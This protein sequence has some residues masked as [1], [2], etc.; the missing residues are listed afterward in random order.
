MTDLAFEIQECLG[1]GDYISASERLRGAIESEPDNAVKNDLRARLAYVQVRQGDFS[2]AL[3]TAKVLEGHQ[4]VNTLTKTSG[5]FLAYCLCIAYS[6]NL[7]SLY[8]AIRR[9]VRRKYFRGG[10]KFNHAYSILFGYYWQDLRKAIQW[11]IFSTC[12][13]TTERD[14]LV[15]IGFLGY[16]LVILGHTAV[17]LRALKK[18]VRAAREA[19]NV[20]ALSE[21]YVFLG[22]G[23]QFAALPNESL[24]AHKEFERDLP[25]ASAFSKVICSA[26]YMN[27][28][29][30]ERGPLEAHQA[31]EAAFKMAVSMTD[32][33]NHIQLYGVRACLNAVVGAKSEALTYLTRSRAIAEKVL[34]RLDMVIYKRFEA[35]VYYLL[36]NFQKSRR[37]LNEAR[38]MLAEYGG[39]DWYY[40]ELDRVEMLLALSEKP[41]IISRTRFAVVLLL[42]GLRFYDFAKFK[43]ALHLGSRLITSGSSFWTEAQLA[44]YWEYLAKRQNESLRSSMARVNEL[45]SVASHIWEALSAGRLTSL[46]SLVSVLEECLGPNTVIVVEAREQLLSEARRRNLAENWVLLNAESHTLKIPC[47]GEQILICIDTKSVPQSDTGCWLCVLTKENDELMLAFF[48]FLI[49]MFLLSFYSQKAESEARK[50]AVYADVAAQVAHDIRS[51]LS[52]LE[53]GVKD[54]SGI[55]EDRRFLIREAKRRITDIAN[56][57]LTIHQQQGKKIP[58]EMTT[59]LLAPIADSL[60]SESRLRFRNYNYLLIEIDLSESYG[61]FAK[62]NVTEIGRVIANL[63]NNSV[64]AMVDKNGTIRVAVRAREAGLVEIEV[65]DNGPGIPPDILKS[66]KEGRQVARKQTKDAGHGLGLS[67]A[68]QVMTGLGGRLEFE[69]PKGGGAIVRMI[70]PRAEPPI[71]F[72]DEVRVAPGAIC[73][74]DD[75]VSV[76]QIWKSR[77]I[78]KSNNDLFHFTSEREFVAWH[79]AGNRASLYLV[80]FEFISQPKDGLQIIEEYSLQ[81]NAILVTSHFDEKN[82]RETAQRLNVRIIPKS[83]AALIPIKHVVVAVSDEHDLPPPITVA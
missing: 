47:R 21:L 72:I 83:M 69:L 42:R 63:I 29:F 51:P 4:P 40:Q 65:H 12:A 77:Q 58:T 19:D 26:S 43:K 18:A 50:K 64:E 34:N 1:H 8:N 81:P 22:V 35:V 38:H 33:R 55:P 70:M 60:V 36:G 10:V 74:I 61:L 80:D 45:Y 75:D 14:Q 46:K 82:V 44:E 5:L 59:E 56:N 67:H 23:Y 13:A 30:T 24:K 54:L 76:F 79:N 32:S 53:V 15:G 25:T 28:A 9:Y 41:G 68:R 71:W 2:S 20:D 37:S 73:V 39:C 52:A 16:T 78:S 17:G 66:I 48:E 27:V 57:L 3:E 62:V 49:R 7:S 6:L 11:N 31:M